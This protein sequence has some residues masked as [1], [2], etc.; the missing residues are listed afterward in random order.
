VALAP[1]LFVLVVW[2]ACAA[3]GP[4]SPEGADAEYA[5]RLRIART[6]QAEHPD[7]PLGLVLGT[8]RTTLAFRPESLTEPDG[9]Y[10]VNAGRAGAIPVLH[11]LMFHRFLRDGVRPA[12]LVL[13]VMPVFFALDAREFLLAQLDL[14]DLWLVRWYA[15]NPFEYDH[16]LLRFRL[17]RNFRT[18]RESAWVVRPQEYLPRGGYPQHEEEVSPTERSTRTNVW[19]DWFAPYRDLTIRPAAARA[20]RDTLREARE[21]GVRVVILHAP[22]GPAFRNWYDPAGLA[23]FDEF[24]AATAAEFG[25]S[26]L[27]ARLW[28]DEDAF[29]DSHHTLRRGADAFTARLAREI[30][31]TPDR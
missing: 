11:R 15:D 31:V 23:R 14:R 19:R 1:P 5:A 28:L 18:V 7:R 12:V 20:F 8:S 6:A 30:P 21:H 24:V 9:V 22:E 26:V 2:A 27:D 4:G 3:A 29:F 25:A 10:W 16:A 13:E 17:G